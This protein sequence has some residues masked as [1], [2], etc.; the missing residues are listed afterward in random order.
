MT[1]AGR[2]AECQA[3]IELFQNYAHPDPMRSIHE[4][5]VTADQPSDGVWT[6]A[7][8]RL[9]IASPEGPATILVPTESVLLLGVDLP[10][11]SRAKRLEALPF[12]IEDRIAEPLDAVHL[13]LGAEIAPRRYL[14]GVVRHDC[15]AAWVDRAEAAGLGQAALVPDALALPVPPEGEWAV[16]LLG[17]RA[18]VRAGDGIGFSVSAALLHQAWEA[19]GRP[20]ALAYGE[21]LPA[22]MQL[23]RRLPTPEPLARRLAAPVL[24][25][26][27]GRYA[28]RSAAVSSNLR[29]LAWIV[30]IGAVAHAGIA[31]ADTLMLR[32]IADKREAETRALVAQV[33]PGVA[34]GDDVALSV[35]DLL[36]TTAAHRQSAFLPLVT[37]VSTAL[38]PLSSAITVHAMG[39]EGARLTMDIDNSEA[40]LQARVADALRGAGVNAQVTGGAGTA[41]IR[42]VA[43]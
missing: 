34:V 3:V 22:E 1:L 29:R 14:V 33:A 6:L 31:A 12:A 37:R 7:G 41:P 23:E 17:S 18:I 16:D 27:Q 42:V 19:A 40:G 25:L 24:D 39:F 5:D 38:A 8:D 9:I 28:R 35:A 43:N 21:P 11:A 10:F 36:P 15:M 4:T 26:R 30:G 13:A 20:P 2:H 32:H